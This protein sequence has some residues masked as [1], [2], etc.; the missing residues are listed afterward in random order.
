MQ[1]DLDQR[2]F[3]VPIVGD[4][5]G[6]EAT[7]ATRKLQQGEAEIRRL[8]DVNVVGVMIWE[9]EGGILEANDAFLRTVGY[10][11]A[12]LVSRRL[13]WTD[14]TP[15]EWRERD[16]RALAELNAIGT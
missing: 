4:A 7:R 3:D 13:R 2:Q 1:P 16:E 11:R 15:A 10:E 14:L 6:K 8:V 12:D 5:K 9:L